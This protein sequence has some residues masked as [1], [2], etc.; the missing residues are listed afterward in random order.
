[1]SGQSYL[2]DRGVTSRTSFETQL[3]GAIL[4]VAFLAYLATEGHG[5]TN[6]FFEVIHSKFYVVSLLGAGKSQTPHSARLKSAVL[7][8]RYTLQLP[9]ADSDPYSGARRV[10]PAP[11]PM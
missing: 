11:R 8:Y 10:S 7:N 4:A 9:S 1:M 5:L 2:T 6:T 3:P